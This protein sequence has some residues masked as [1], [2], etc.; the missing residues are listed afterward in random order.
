MARRLFYIAGAIT[1]ILIILL[2]V[3]F[4]YA[5]YQVSL[6]PKLEVKSLRIDNANGYPSVI[7]EFSTD[8]YDFAFK[9]FDEKGE[10]VDTNTP[11][12]GATG[13][14]L[15]LVG[16]KPYT[17]ILEP[18]TYVL[19]AFYGDKEIYSKTI[20]INGTSMRARLLNYTAELVITGLELK[21]LTHSTKNDLGVH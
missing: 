17:N 11:T 4:L 7:V 2:I 16:L 13:A 5:M 1:F 15:S 6:P 10:L 20:T 12:A 9:L 3:M 8:K 19:K 21:S 18:R 14:S